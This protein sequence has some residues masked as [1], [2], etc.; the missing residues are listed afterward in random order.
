MDPTIQEVGPGELADVVEPGEVTLVLGAPG[1]GTSQQL[2]SLGQTVER[3]PATAGVDDDELVVVDDF[4]SAVFAL[5][6]EHPSTYS[7]EFGEKSLFA[8]AGGAVL[9][10][11]PRSF[12]WLCRSDVGIG[13]GFIETV[14]T[15]VTVRTPPTA[16]AAAINDVRGRIEKRSPGGLRDG[17]RAAVLEQTWYPPYYFETAE[18]QNHLGWYDAT[19]T[20]AAFLSLSKYDDT[21]VLMPD[22]VR[23]VFGDCDSSIGAWSEEFADSISRLVPSGCL[24]SHIPNERS[25][26]VLAAVALV[27]VGLAEDAD[28]LESL[29]RYRVL[30]PAAE[31]LE[32][33]LD[34]PP[35]T[36]D[37]LR[38]FAADPARAVIRDR[39]GSDANRESVVGLA[40]NEIREAVDAL[41]SAGSSFDEIST[42]PEEYG[43]SR[44][45]GAWHWDGPQALRESAAE[46]E[47][48]A[49]PQEPDE[50][51]GETATDWT[52]LVDGDEFLDALDGGLVVLSGPKASGKRRLAASLASELEEWGTT[53]VLPDLTHPDHIRTG[54]DA[55][56]NAVV[57]ATYGAGP[58]RITS[59]D[60]VRA[61]PEW[62]TEGSCTGAL[63]ICDDSDR[64]R[65]DDTCERAG[66]DELAAWNDRVE[67]SLDE[68]NAVSDR[69]PE[70][71]AG[72][73]L[74]AI[75][76]NEVQSP[77]RRTVDVESVTDQSTLAAVS[78]VPDH[79][80]T[81]EFVGHV[82]AEAVDIISTTHGPDAAQQWLSFIDDLVA[83]VGRNRSSDTDESVR[84]RGEVYGTAIAAVATAEPT[85][86]EWVHAVAR[87][88]LTLTNETATPRGQ[89][90]AGG[91]LEPF[92]TAFSGALA[93]LAQPPDG[94][95]VNH[96]AIGC[97]DQAL[98]DAVSDDVRQ[99]PLHFVYGS[100]V[101]QIVH[102][103]ED[104]TT[105]NGGLTT[106]FS[107]VRQYA[108]SPSDRST[109]VVLQN[110]VGSMIGAVAGLEC[111]P[112]ELSAWIADIESR[113]GD[114]TALINDPDARTAILEESYAAGIGLWV[115]EHGCPDDVFAP[116]L[117][118]VGH[119][120]CQTAVKA[121][122]D[123]PETFVV[124]AYGRAVRA[125]IRTGELDRA[126]QLFS[127]CHRL[128]DTIAS[129]NHFANE[130]E[131]RASLH[132]K[133]LASFGDV[134]RDHPDEVN[135]YPYGSDSIPF[136]DSLGFEDWIERYDEAAMRGAASDASTAETRRYL[137]DIY[138][139]ALST[140]VRGYDPDSAGSNDGVRPRRERTWYT[141]L[142]ERIE[143]RATTTDSVD[144]PLTF[145]ADVF[146]GA[147]VHWA[148]NGESSRTREWIEVLVRSLRTS[149]KSVDGPSTTEWYD[150]FAS[151]DAEILVA[152]LTRT[153]V[154]ERT[155]E[156]LVEAVLS[157]IEAAATAPDN[158]PHPVEYVVSVFG[159]ALALAADAPPEGV[160]FGV[161][162]ALAV[163]DDGV[164]LERDGTER[165]EVFE[166]VYAEAF[167]NVSRTHTDASEAAAWLEIVSTTIEA[168]ATEQTQERSAAF[169]A[170]VYVRSLFQTA[171]NGADGWYQRLDAELREYA[172][173]PSVDDPAA[174][175]E[176]V[177]ADVVV[178]GA[179]RH[180]SERRIETCIEA[181]SESIRAATDG[182]VIR[183]ND[184][185]ERTISRVAET[186]L[187]A[188]VRNRGDYMRRLDRGL[189]KTGSEDLANDVFDGERSDDSD[190][191]PEPNPKRKP[192]N[193]ST[194]QQDR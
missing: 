168:I 30:S 171:Q 92:A 169:V 110:S 64:E 179:K 73:L 13:G 69:D 147:A 5:G 45:V 142:T 42:G 15:V 49:P 75:G 31:A 189:R 124:D 121:D 47:L 39:L 71:V 18:L 160:R 183:S 16:A 170:A 164:S 7:Y 6:E 40:C 190:S 67:F 102:R 36:V 65:L 97:V 136:D 143:A 140:H 48:P 3:L 98:H 156:R 152:V 52:S 180:G 68:P 135:Q 104:P 44:L 157:R 167:A 35:G 119:S 105:A 62:V 100:A 79:A 10:T 162:E 126:E 77:S 130:W 33:S 150:A 125:V 80:L 172:N 9:V 90:S 193:T 165:T 27:A 175:L 70:T 174:F 112:E 154:G 59:D 94:T 186:L 84:Y 151:A 133:A 93:T 1:I 99:F 23:E 74:D 113:V 108:M 132:A 55:T 21:E 43:S 11:R 166:R 131:L 181:V 38:V 26:P 163:L 60:G 184:A 144:D 58:A 107:L 81:G 34:L 83:D 54:I 91:D 53:V 82:V 28:W 14:D 120:M 122:L 109:A 161:T 50:T 17:E 128:V 141:G 111:P 24:P 115:F 89:E 148:A 116:W 159:G 56:P 134:E 129:S 194:G 96:G 29:A 22:D 78:G 12:D 191:E 192:G 61:L 66:C 139:G 118:A 41:Q 145:L 155:H 25:P 88:V 138:C 185:F 20:P 95:R 127:N 51:P 114:A 146:G 149:R 182:D 177:Y 173:G 57:V 137:T 46:R 86:D 76:W 2:Q 72:D 32:L 153:D 187:T 19:V 63:L 117:D 37:H 188:D 123:D 4:V 8:R 101:E 178:K 87:G 106:L 85:T 158:P 176:G 103:A